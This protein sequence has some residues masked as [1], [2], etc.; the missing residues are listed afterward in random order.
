MSDIADVTDDRTEREMELLIAAAR[1]PPAEESEAPSGEC[2]NGCGTPALAGGH[3]CS[4]E[5]ADD[6]FARK[7]LRKRQGAA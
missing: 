3:H 4:K 6:H 1:R 7:Q 2:A 5:C